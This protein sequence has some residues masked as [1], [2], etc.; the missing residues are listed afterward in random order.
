MRRVGA[1]QGMRTPL[2][3]AAASDRIRDRE[4]YL[5]LGAEITVPEFVL[6]YSAELGKETYRKLFLTQKGDCFETDCP[7][8]LLLMIPNWRLWQL[9]SYDGDHV[10]IAYDAD[11][12]KRNKWYQY[13]NSKLPWKMKVPRMNGDLVVFKKEAPV[14][15]NELEWRRELMNFLVTRYGR[16]T[17]YKF[18]EH[19]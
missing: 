10:Y 6:S 14:V 5:R 19:K 3:P 13:V 12:A 8:G 16:K 7:V 11:A 4:D 2:T 18:C 15:W 1:R 17:D 9:S